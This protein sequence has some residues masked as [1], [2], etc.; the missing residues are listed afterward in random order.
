MR[1]LTSTPSAQYH[2]AVSPDGKRILYQETRFDVDIAKVNLTD[3]KVI[4]L[5]A[6]ERDESMPAW[7]ARVGKFAYATDR[8]GPPEIWMRSEDG[9]DRP[10]VTPADFA[11][12]V[13]NFFMDPTPTPD[14]DRV[15]YTMGE[16]GGRLLLYISAASGGSPIRVTNSSRGVEI[17]GSL[18][19][20]GK[21]LAYLS[22]DGNQAHLMLVKTSGQATPSLLRDDTNS[23]PQWSPTGEWIAFEDNNGWHLISPDGKKVHDIG[24]ISAGHLAFSL[25]GKKLFGIRHDKEHQYLFS[26]DVNGD[27]SALKTIADIG[28]DYAPASNLN[29]G[30]RLSVA[31]DGT[32][33]IYSIATSKSSIWLFEGF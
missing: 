13:V 2:P 1:R 12:T 6:T 18:S 20:D 29:P 16:V 22:I 7:A 24:K 28:Q 9:A 17:P 5:I 23:L 11:P 26:L 10:L 33:A 8:N 30:Y 15:I 32:C 19:A 21:Q 25:D 27:S 14:G 4:R 3:G 31:P